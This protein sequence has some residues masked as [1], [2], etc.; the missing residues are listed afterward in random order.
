MIKRDENIKMNKEGTYP[1]YIDR[2][3]EEYGNTW[4]RLDR[5]DSIKPNLFKK[6]PDIIVIFENK[7]DPLFV[8]DPGLVVSIKEEDGYMGNLDYRLKSKK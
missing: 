1:D 3:I 2:H 7:N 5:W 8:E 4:I 6:Y